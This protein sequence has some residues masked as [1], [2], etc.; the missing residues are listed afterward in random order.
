[1]IQPVATR[2]TTADVGPSWSFGRTWLATYAALAG[3][4]LFIGRELYLGAPLLEF[5]DLAANALQIDRAKELGEIY[6]NYSRF[7]FHHPGPAFFYVYAGAEIVFHDLLRLTAAPHNAHLLGG[8]LLQSAFLA[9]AI[10]VVARYAAP[11][12]VLFIALAIGTGLLH[13]ALAGEQHYSIWPPSVLVL[14]FACFIVLAAAL[15]AGWIGILPLVV[16]VGGFLVHGHVAQPLFVLPIGLIAYAAGVRRRS[17]ESGEPASAVIG[18][19]GGTHVL[20]LAVLAVFLV[21]LLID[22]QLGDRSNIASIVRVLTAPRESGDTYSPAQVIGYVI[23]FF[24]YPTMLGELDFQPRELLDFVL[25]SWLAFAALFLLIVVAPAARL[26]I[27]SFRARSTSPS[28]RPIVVE[29]LGRLWAFTGLALGLTVV[30]V[31]IQR[32]PL[33]QFN[34]LFMYGLIYV[35]LLPGALLAC[36]HFA[37][38]SSK[39]ATAVLGVAVMAMAATADPPPNLGIDPTLSDSTNAYVAESPPPPGGVLLFF[40]GMHWNAPAAVALALERLDVPW[41]VEPHWGLI[42]GRSHALLPGSGAAPPLTWSLAEPS[43]DHEGQIV[44]SDAVAIYPPPGRR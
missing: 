31:V 2:D 33:Y 14:P 43:T 24:G 8:I 16:L 26:L 40:D 41:F 44:L 3:V 9:L 38:A 29:P 11:N 32:G 30:W 20:A 28:V 23:S 19:R 36:R 25:R 17:R 4:M 37:R 22:A 39:I 18:R 35:A 10:A 1:M 42:F 7:G 13:F 21:P 6:G 27:P 34:S 5:G 15:S 12:R